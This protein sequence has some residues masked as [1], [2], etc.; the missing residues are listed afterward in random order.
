MRRGEA[1]AR[2]MA[3]PCK[4]QAASSTETPSGWEHLVNV[5]AGVL[6]DKN[7]G[8]ARVGLQLDACG[9]QLSREQKR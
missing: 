7:G 3:A 5:G 9:L 8:A 2:R 4:R 1:A 6:S